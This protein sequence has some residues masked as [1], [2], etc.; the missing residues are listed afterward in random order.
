MIEFSDAAIGAAGLIG[1]AIVTK[2]IEAFFEKKKKTEDEL[3]EKEIAAQAVRDEKMQKIES[4][5]HELQLAFA[6][7]T[8]KLEVVLPKLDSLGK[9]REDMAGF[10]NWKREQGGSK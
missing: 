9:I 6:N 8:G 3:S 1:G 2:L 5:L 7:L 4:S 10:Y